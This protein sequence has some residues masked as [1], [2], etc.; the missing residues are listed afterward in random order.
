MILVLK[1][2]ESIPLE[3]QPQLSTLLLLHHQ[4][5]SELLTVKVTILLEPDWDNL[6]SFELNWMELVF[7]TSLPEILLPK[8]VWM[9]K[10]LYFWM[11]V[12]ALQIQSF[13]DWKKTI[14]QGHCWE[15][16]RLSNL[17]TLLLLTLK[18][19]CNFAK[20]NV[21]LSIVAMA[22]NLMAEER[23]GKQI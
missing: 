18:S 2:M 10:R 1:L 16:L 19:M 23:E 13:Q 3:Y 11:I 12:V 21:I 5:F 7:L 6:C 20:K 22:L 9:K 14:K 15:N 17:V 8:V 4:L